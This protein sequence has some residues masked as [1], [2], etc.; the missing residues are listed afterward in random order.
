MV[1]TM[2]E[3]GGLNS[4]EN[5]AGET[6]REPVVGIPGATE[7]KFTE[8][9]RNARAIALQA[10]FEWDA[11]KHPP[12]DSLTWIA[13]DFIVDADRES[14]LSYASILVEDV[15]EDEERLDG[16]IQAHATA[17]PVSQLAAVDRNAI[18]LAL[19]EIT[20]QRV[21][22][23]MAIDEAVELAKTYGAESSARFVHG[24]LGGVLAELSPDL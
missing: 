8:S 6:V 13:D 2:S 7:K 21:P 11:V 18:R 19:T 14:V 10:L 23:A 17:Y 20:H 24:V 3:S 12:D 22:V 9:R 5:A 16:L 15:Q 1:S 4:E